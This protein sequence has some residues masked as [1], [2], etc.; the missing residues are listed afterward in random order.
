MIPGLVRLTEHVYAVKVPFVV[1]VAPGK[2]LRRFVYAYLVRGERTLLI[3]SGVAGA[4]D[5]ILAALADLDGS[6]G[7]VTT[8]LLTHSHPDHI[9]G[10]AALRRASGCRVL[11]HPAERA[12]IEDIAVQQAQRP[13]PGFATLVGGSVPVDG[14]L[15]DGDRLSWPPLGELRVLHTPGHSP[16]SL[17]LWLADEGVLFTGDAVP[18]PGTMPI[19]TD[20]AAAASSLQALLRLQGV[21]LLCSSWEEPRHGE[22]EARAALTAGLAYLGD[23]HAAVSASMPSSD[24]GDPLSLCRLVAARLGLPPLAVNPLMATSV[25]AHRRLIGKPGAEKLFQA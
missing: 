1:P 17:S 6:A 2:A 11:A 9:G 24:P 12:W 5:A 14:T 8:L 16:G 10:A 13:V 18:Q 3:D 22:A 20:A 7:D 19:Y 15:Q 4:E 21:R 23:V 25:E